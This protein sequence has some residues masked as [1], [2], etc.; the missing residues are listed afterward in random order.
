MEKQYYSNPEKITD[1]LMPEKINAILEAENLANSPSSKPSN[2]LPI[3]S[4]NHKQENNEESKKTSSPH[5]T[6]SKQPSKKL[7]LEDF[8][9]IRN[10]GKGS[11]GEVILVK[12]K[13]DGKSYAMKAIDKNFLYKVSFSLFIN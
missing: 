13:N 2:E 11:F 9:Y 8:E 10:L 6:Q 7:C 5:K 1:P 3:E 4:N 12:K